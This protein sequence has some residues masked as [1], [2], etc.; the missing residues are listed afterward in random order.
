[1]VSLDARQFAVRAATVGDLAVLPEIERQAHSIIYG[2]A[3]LGAVAELPPATPERLRHGPCWVALDR[4]PR[5][6]GFVLAGRLDNNALIETLAILP[7]FG[8]S[9]LG[10]ALVSAAIDWAKERDAAAMLVAAYR[11]MP[12]DA[13]FYARLGFSEVPRRQWSH[14]M[15]RLGREAAAAGHDPAR[16]LWMRLSLG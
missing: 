10:R 8:G 11:D 4:N 15:H 13:P 6:V 14:E 1:M 9:G 3:G 7:E 5:V 16:R 2:M 12:W